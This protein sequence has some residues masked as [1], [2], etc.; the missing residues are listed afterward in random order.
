VSTGR[1]LDDPVKVPPRGDGVVRR[2]A[3]LIAR[4]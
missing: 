2:R 4:D 3:E 1:K